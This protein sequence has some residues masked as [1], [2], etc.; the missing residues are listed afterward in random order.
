M[1]IEIPAEGIIVNTAQIETIEN[2]DDDNLG[3][4]RCTITFANGRKE[5]VR[6]DVETIRRN[7]GTVIPAPAG[8]KLIRFILPA[9][10]EGSTEAFFY[11]EDVL[12]FRFS[13]HGD[14]Q[15]SP[16]G[17][18]GEPSDWD[19][20]VLS[21]NGKV[22]TPDQSWDTVEEFKRAIQRRVK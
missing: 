8:H 9:K 4:S 15:M 20:G 16:I 21:P 17:V 7:T 22:D 1:L 10:G 5:I 19:Y 2:V 6:G 11:E 3:R 14:P 13:P 18:S 12:A